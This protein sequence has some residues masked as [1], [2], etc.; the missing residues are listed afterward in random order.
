MRIDPL[1]QDFD[2]AGLARSFAAAHPFRFVCID[3]LL[4]RGFAEEVAQAY[5]RYDIAAEHGREFRALHESHK[6]Q[7]TDSDAFPDA[8]SRLA[9]VLAGRPFMDLISQITGIPD[10][11]PDDR[12]VGGGMHLMASRGRLDVHVDFNR[13]PERGLHRRLNFLVFLNSEWR[14]EWGGLLELWDERVRRCRHAFE[15]VLNRC[16]IFETNEVSFHG[17]T[18][19]ECPAHLTRNSFAGYYYTRTPAADW[20]GVDHT[21]RFRPRPGERLRTGFLAPAESMARLARRRS[22]A[23]RRALRWLPV[24]QTR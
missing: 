23:I 12:N 9:R 22:G 7:I 1:F 8:V 11:V 4:D 24:R 6:V 20:K 15:P 21:T 17:V 3:G 10:L 18:P 5:P 19:L 13:L 14:S 16:V 2:V